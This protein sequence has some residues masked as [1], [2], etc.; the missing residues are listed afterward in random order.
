MALPEEY[1]MVLSNRNRS[2][3]SVRVQKG[4]KPYIYILT[5]N[6]GRSSVITAIT[7]RNL[8]VLDIYCGHKRGHLGAN[9]KPGRPKMILED[10]WSGDGDLY[11]C[12][13]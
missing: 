1:I 11:T 8:D 9:G 5:S 13:L 6:F 10:Q 2:R 4:R 7:P 3:V 12:R